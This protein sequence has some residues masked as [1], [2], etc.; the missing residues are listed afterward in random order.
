MKRYWWQRRRP[1]QLTNIALREDFEAFLADAKTALARGLTI[2]EW[3]ALKV[4]ERTER[5]RT[6]TTAP[7]FRATA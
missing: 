6:V 7:R 1:R 2:A 3:R 5:R 4:R